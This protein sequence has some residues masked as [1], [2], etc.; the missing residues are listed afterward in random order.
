[1]L[2]VAPEFAQLLPTLKDPGE[3]PLYIHKKLR[4]ALGRPKAGRHRRS[5]INPTIP[6]GK[7]KRRGEK[8]TKRTA[9]A[10]RTKNGKPPVDDALAAQ[11]RPAEEATI[12][13]ALSSASGVPPKAPRLTR[14]PLGCGSC[15]ASSAGSPASV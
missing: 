11:V 12:G 8:A 1:M 7:R 5:K 13:E 14:P 4:P 15:E 2:G 6:R 3:E 10:A 9:E